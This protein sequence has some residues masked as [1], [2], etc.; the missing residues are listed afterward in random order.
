MTRW[1]GPMYLCAVLGIIYAFFA[2]P[3]SIV[4]AVSMVAFMFKD[5]SERDGLEAE[6]VDRAMGN[7]E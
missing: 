2:L 4:F 1:I 6:K 3:V 7:N 5:A